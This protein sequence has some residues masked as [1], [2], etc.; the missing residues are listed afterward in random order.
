MFHVETTA[1]EGEHAYEAPA[2]TAPP[3]ATEKTPND[4]ERPADGTFASYGSHFWS[5]K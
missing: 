4:Q 2:T 1:W 5:K 3:K